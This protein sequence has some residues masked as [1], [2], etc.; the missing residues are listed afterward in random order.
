MKIDAEL[1]NFLLTEHGLYWRDTISYVVL[2]I[3][4]KGLHF[5]LLLISR[6]YCGNPSYYDLPKNST[7]NDVPELIYGINNFDNIGSSVLTLF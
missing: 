3:A 7:E 4:L 5:D 1:V 6:S 2:R